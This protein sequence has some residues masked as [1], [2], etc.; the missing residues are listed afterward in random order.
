MDGKQRWEVGCVVFWI[1]R[2]DL[3][4]YVCIWVLIVLSRFGG[5]MFVVNVDTGNVD[6]GDV[7]AGDGRY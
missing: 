7:D 4:M 1:L 2:D 5:G 3:Y 6:A